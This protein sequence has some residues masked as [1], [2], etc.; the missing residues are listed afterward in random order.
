MTTYYPVVET[1]IS[2]GWFPV[3]GTYCNSFVLCTE[4]EEGFALTQKSCSGD[5][6][7]DHVNE[8]CTY[9]FECPEK[10][11]AY[12]PE[13]LTCRSACAQSGMFTYEW[14]CTKYINCA[15]DFNFN[16]CSMRVE[17]CPYGLTFNGQYCDDTIQC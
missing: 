15:V 10:K 9:D 2:V 8:Y 7:Y 14:D 5:L 11:P 13:S 1:C 17:Q 12:G 3:P 4:T 6:M 16:S